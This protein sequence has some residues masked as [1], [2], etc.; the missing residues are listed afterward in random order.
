MTRPEPVWGRLAPLVAGVVLVAS[1]VTISPVVGHVSRLRQ[2]PSAGEVIERVR[3][4]TERK[5]CASPD[6]VRCVDGSALHVGCDEAFIASCLALG[7]QWSCDETLGC[8]G[9][10]CRCE[11][12][13]CVL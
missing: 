5:D 9:A 11:R 12:G 1:V 4:R 7:G 8:P 10:D 3:T 6:T 2:R 13:E